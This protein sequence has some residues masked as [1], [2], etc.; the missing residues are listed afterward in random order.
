[1]RLVSID[2]R[3]LCQSLIGNFLREGRRELDL[4][5]IRIDQSAITIHSGDWILGG[6]I[7]ERLVFVDFKAN[8]G[9]LALQNQVAG[10]YPKEV[11][12]KIVSSLT[13]CDGT[14]QNNHPLNS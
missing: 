2:E 4:P 13:C 11:S 1:M 8:P 5:V 10:L 6:N 3:G 14:W 9:N 7:I 12:L